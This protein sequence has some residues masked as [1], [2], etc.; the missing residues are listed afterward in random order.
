MKKKNI[1]SNNFILVLFVMLISIQYSCK[2]KSNKYY[3]LNSEDKSTY[4]EVIY[5]NNCLKIFERFN[6]KSKLKVDL[7]LHDDEYIH[8]ID[9][10]TKK[11]SKKS[12]VFLSTKKHTK[13]LEDD[14]SL[15]NDS[16][17]TGNTDGELYFTVVKSNLKPV[18]YKYFYDKEYRVKKII[19][20]LGNKV[21]VYQ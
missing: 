5:E 17:I 13:L 9:Y 21:A 6:K 11:T 2:D 1:M 18:K 20:N 16:I 4:F 10:N 8:K 12:Y 7:I 3:L 15:L 19:Y 14:F